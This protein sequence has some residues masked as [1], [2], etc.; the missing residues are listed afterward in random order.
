MGHFRNRAHNILAA[1]KAYTEGTLVGS[2][3][4]DAAQ[5]VENSGS[6]QFKSSVARMMNMLIT[7]FTKNGSTDCEQFRVGA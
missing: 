5:N 1:C 4:G 3:S 6:K 2:V 7:N